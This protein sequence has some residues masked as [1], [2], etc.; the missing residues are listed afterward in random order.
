MGAQ[1]EGESS[2][3]LWR[4]TLY[5][6]DGI[7][8]LHMDRKSTEGTDKDNSIP[9]HW[10]GTW[11]PMEASDA[12]KAPAPK[13]NAF[14][15]Y[16][17]SDYRFDI[18]GSAKPLTSE[19]GKESASSSPGGMFVASVT[20]GAGWDMEDEETKSKQKYQD[21]THEVLVK[22]LKWSG[23]MFDQTENLIV[24]KGENKFGPFVS[25]GWMR[26]GNRWTLAR[27]YLPEG[28]PRSKMTLLELQVAVMKE[29]VTL[30]EDTGQ[31]QLKIPP[32]HCSVLHSEYREKEKHRG[33]KRKIEEVATEVE[34]Q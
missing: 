19:E 6:W 33:E 32:W 30:M 17:D 25:A 26:P 28:D 8:S 4:D 13:R 16:V 18:D 31:Q 27:R 12:T 20:D 3:S 14:A 5:V 10:E 11:V 23:N 2:G 22:S 7:V 21:T 1:A 29:T 24:A 34:K 15:E 9:I